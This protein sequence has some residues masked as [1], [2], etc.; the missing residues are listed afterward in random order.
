MKPIIIGLQTQVNV[1]VSK[2][3]LSLE[4]ILEISGYQPIPNYEQ[5][6]NDFIDAL[7]GNYSVAFLEALHVASAKRIVEHW[8]EYSPKRLEEERYKKYLSYE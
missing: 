3:P 7:D 4:E 8:R 5:Q 2:I 1:E 6:A